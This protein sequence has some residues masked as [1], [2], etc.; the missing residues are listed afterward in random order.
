MRRATRQARKIATTKRRILQLILAAALCGLP[1]GLL[2]V[3]WGAP[4][5]PTAKP[6]EFAGQVVIPPRAVLRTRRISL[7]LLRVGTPFRAQAFADSHG[8]FRFHKIPPGTYNLSIR[9]P[10]FGELQNTVDV[11]ASFADS[12]GRVQ[13]T[14]SYDEAALAHQARPSS[15]GFVSVRELSIP[16]KARR[17]FEKAQGDLQ[18][19]KVDSAR[20]HF[21]KAVE[22]A[23]QYTEALNDLGVIAFQG[24]NF[25]AAEMYFRKA[26]EKEPR[27]FEPLVNLGGALLALDRADEA[28]EVNARAHEERPADP[29]AAAQLGMS[30]YVAGNDEEALNYLLLTEQLDPNHY[31]NPQLALAKIYLSRSD[32]QAASAELDDFLKRHPDSPEAEP[33]R[34]MLSTIGEMRQA[35]RAAAASR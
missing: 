23:P 29:L 10:G 4:A 14:Y 24:R 22:I 19:G 3:A 21:E 18:H 5:S 2:N 16:W 27:A 20:Q 34:A 28:I 12:K 11:T 30:Y 15:G 1:S 13:K 17:E 35:P 25:P 26:L 32:T 33:V 31:T 6:L 8:R 9:I 7:T